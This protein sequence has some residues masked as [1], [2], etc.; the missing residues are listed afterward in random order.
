MRQMPACLF[1]AATAIA[2]GAAA[3][4]T[5]SDLQ[6]H[7]SGQQTCV[8][9]ALDVPCDTVGARLRDQGTPRDAHIQLI[10]GT[11]SSYQ[12]ISAALT[13]LRDAGFQLKLGYINVAPDSVPVQTPTGFSAPSIMMILQNFPLP[14]VD[15]NLAAQI[16]RAV[17]AAKYP[18]A[19]LSS[20]VPEILDQGDTWLV[21][22]KV[23]QW[24]QAPQ[25][26]E[27]IKAIP[28]SIRKRDAAIVDI[29]PHGV[30]DNTSPEVVRKQME[31]DAGCKKCHPIGH[32][33]SAN[34]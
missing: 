18:I 1:V 32:G 3:S 17:V 23:A 34:K 16:G 2:V 9:G 7:I 19:V 31:T 13:S 10:P 12:A 26:F 29:F 5:E 11:E 21:T 8:V 27:G 22:L 30:A 20:D 28:I 24:T 33:A 4:Q 6:I 14:F 25:L 15:R